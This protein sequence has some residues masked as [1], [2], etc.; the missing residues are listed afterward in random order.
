MTIFLVSH[1]MWLIQT[2]SS[3]AILLENGH[4]RG[5]GGALKVI[6]AYKRM[7]HDANG[8]EEDNLTSTDIKSKP[9]AKIT[10]FEV[11]PEGN[12]ATERKAFSGL[13]RSHCY[14]H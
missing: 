14:I 5:Q 4:I 7:T 13:R 3:R 9:Q 2:I 11:L 8:S 12:W 1:N 10:L 6:E